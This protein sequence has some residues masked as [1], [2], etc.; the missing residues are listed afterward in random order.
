[1]VTHISLLFLL[2]EYCHLARNAFLM[3]AVLTRYV[4]RPPDPTQRYINNQIQSQKHIFTSYMELNSNYITMIKFDLP[5]ARLGHLSLCCP[6]SH[7]SWRLR[8]RGGDG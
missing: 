7:T 6:K 4:P 1:M 3:R 8:R 5:L 2:M